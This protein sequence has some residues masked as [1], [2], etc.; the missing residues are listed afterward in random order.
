MQGRNAFFCI[1]PD[2]ANTLCVFA[3]NRGQIENRI[4][5]KNNYYN[6]TKTVNQIQKVSLGQLTTEEPCYGTSAT[7]VERTSE[8]QPKYIRITDFDDFGIGENHEFMT[9]DNYSEKHFLQLH[10]IL[11][12]RTGSVGRTFY[13]DGKIG[14]A[15]FA[16]YCIRFR[17]DDK[18]VLPK[19]VYWY[20]KTK[21]YADWVQGIQRPS[22][23]PNINKEEYKSFEIPLPNLDI[24]QKAVDFMNDAFAK[25][26]SKLKQADEILSTAKAQFFDTL[27]I[28]FCEY[29]P[30]LF[31]RTTLGAAREIGVYCNPHSDYLNSV[32]TRVKANKYYAGDLEDFAQVNPTMSRKDLSDDTIVSFVPMLAVTEKTN[33]VVYDQKRYAEVKTGFTI[34]QKGDL[35]WAKITPCMQNG[36]SF[37]ADGM[38]TEI[39]FGSTEFHVLRSES[40]KLY[41]PFLWVLL[42]D[43]HILEAAQGMFGGS[44]GQQ[45]VPDTFLKKFPIILPPVETQKDLADNVFSALKQAKQLRCEA[46]QELLTARAQFEKELLG[47]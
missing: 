8:E 24:Q 3:V 17:F 38:P 4:D 6:L 13:Y 10:D 44:A 23:Q 40:D 15:I 32:F 33:E 26:Q 14:S 47:E 2:E 21:Q 9:A 30:S 18:K 12:A 43:E 45:R 29:K 20:T 37:L 22:V 34:F 7:A 1:T 36:K 31:S 39:G 5:V 16:G 46:Q 35:L 25:R 19:F 41:M 42:C 11:F 28:N 27:D